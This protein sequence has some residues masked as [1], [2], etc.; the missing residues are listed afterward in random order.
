MRIAC[1]CVCALRVY[2]LYHGMYIQFF[3]IIQ[4]HSYRHHHR[5]RHLFV[6]CRLP[7]TILLRHGDM[8]LLRRLWMATATLGDVVN[9]IGWYQPLYLARP[10]APLRRHL[11]CVWHWPLCYF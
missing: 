9:I 1:V 6:G 10:L 8:V 11:E 2:V 3:R 7:Q 4:H 5:R